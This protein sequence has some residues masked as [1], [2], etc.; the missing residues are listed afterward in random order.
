MP[1]EHRIEVIDDEIEPEIRE[2]EKVIEPITEEIVEETVVT[3]Q[4]RKKLKKKAYKQRKKEKENLEQIRKKKLAGNF[5]T[6]TT[7]LQKQGQENLEKWEQ[8]ANMINDYKKKFDCFPNM[9]SNGREV[10]DQAAKVLGRWLW[11]QTVSYNKGVMNPYH[12]KRLEEIGFKF[13]SN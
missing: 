11:L 1:N 6:D 5:D 9:R 13:K 3:A 4:E 7:E 10:N 2:E 12:I 8:M